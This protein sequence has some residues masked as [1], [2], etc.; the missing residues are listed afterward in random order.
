MQQE[1]SQIT[2]LDSAIAR[3]LEIIAKPENANKFLR[4]GVS[5][6]GCSGFQYLFNLDDKINADD[7]KI[8]EQNSRILAI[9]DESA[10]PFLNGCV[11]DFVRDLGASYF[12]VSNPNA[13][14]SCGCGSSFSV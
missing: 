1:N 7:I 11:I 9:T 4:I 12:K 14:A 6:G 5:S 3:V 2:L 10:L 8:C 13:S